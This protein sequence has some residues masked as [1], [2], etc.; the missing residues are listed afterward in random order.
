MGFYAYYPPTNMVTVVGPVSVTQGTSP[1]V[2]GGTVTAN[3]GTSPWIISGSV[4]QGTSPWVVSGTV[5]STQ[6]GTWTTGR[7]WVLDSSTDSVNIGN[8]P[9][10]QAVSQSG[11]WNISTLD[12][13][14]NPVTVNQGTSPWV[15]SGTVTANA[16]TNLNTSLLALDSTVA[17]DATLVTINTSINTLLKPADTLTAVT[18]LGSITNAL[19]AGANVI[20]H[21]I[22]DSGSVVNATLSAETTKVIGTVNQGTSPWVIS[23]TATV[24]G[25][26][27][28]TQSGTWNIATLTTLTSITNPVAVTQS[29]TWTTGRTWTLSSGTDSISASVS[30]F[31]ATVAV[32]QSTSPWVISGAVTGSGN[33]TVTQATGTNL[34]TVIDSGAVTATLSAET[35]KVIGTVNIASGQTVGLVAGSAVIGHVITDSGSVTAATLSAETTKVI[36]TVNISAAQTVGLVAGSAVIGHVINDAGSAIIG[37]VGIDQT[38]PGTTNLVALAAN[39]SV[40]VA[41]VNGNTTVASVTG[42]QDVMPR[43]RTGSTGLSPIY[44][45]SHITAKTT[46]TPTSATAYVSSIAIACSGAGTAWTMVIRDKSG[47]PLILI[48]SFTLTIPTTGLPIILNFTEPIIMASGIDIITAGTTAGTVD[49]FITYWQ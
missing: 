5:A 33:F 43:K 45:T 36:G 28:A 15:I 29:G 39:Q 31:P 22:T 13:I 19:P 18:T 35:T 12:T 11:I 1:W 47:T 9:A 48:P 2:V 17:K 41:Q 49:V 26:V 38:T 16:G 4:T 10:I 3:Q 30:N 44:S 24:S 42:V 37:K 23:G 46:T 8:F 32:T 27:A 21:V 14:T 25:T 6:S 7:T 34:H 20:G 40:N